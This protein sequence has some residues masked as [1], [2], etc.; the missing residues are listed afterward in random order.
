MNH[1]R[2]LR[3]ALWAAAFF[4]LAAT[5]AGA[6]TRVASRPFRFDDPQAVLREKIF[7]LLAAIQETPEIRKEVARDAALHHLL[8]QRDA[9]L[10]QAVKD[11]ADM[12]CLAA[13]LLVTPAESGKASAAL[14]ALYHKSRRFRSFIHGNIRASGFY[15]LS[16]TLSDSLLL[17]KAWKEEVA[18]FNHIVNAYLQNKDLQYP[19]IDS[20]SFYVN[21]P[22]YLDT[23]Q[24]TLSRLLDRER[25][26]AAFFSSEL[27]ACLAILRLNGRNEAGRF[28][29]KDKTNGEAY[30]RI[31][32]VDWKQYPYSCILVFGSGPARPEVAISDRNKERCRAGVRLFRAGRAPF[33]IVSGGYVHPFRTRYCEA[34]EMKTYMEDSLGVPAN[35]IIMEPHARHTTTN[36]RNANRIIFRQH[37]P[38]NMPV[39]GVSAPSHIKYMT[40]GRLATTCRRDL[41]YVPYTDIKGVA[42]D[43]MSYMPS[44]SSLQ[45]NTREPLDP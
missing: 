24:Y 4:I 15:A 19:T 42:A 18:G 32:S 31:P 13:A 8:V 28:E 12:K 25:S 33:I 29:P 11:C 39:L 5:T 44:R 36:I 41:G 1:K 10:Q 16:D 45:I 7:Y 40:S 21:S 37:I 22:G 35:A 20:A 38:A 27:D 43:Q 23:V 3:T 2:Y 6:Q 34:Q 9:A 30:D 14:G 17:I 26:G